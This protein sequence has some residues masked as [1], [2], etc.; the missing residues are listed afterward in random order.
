MRTTAE[1]IIFAINAA[2]R[3]GRN[4]Q[5][6]YAKS[7]KSKAIVLPLPRIIN[8][9]NKP[10][11]ARRFFNN[12]S[13]VNGGAQFVGEIEEL[14]DLHQ[15]ANDLGTTRPLS[16][17]EWA[18]YSSYFERFKTTLEAGIAGDLPADY[19]NVEEL[20]ALLRIRQ[21]ERGK[22]AGT[23]PLQIVAGTLVEI[24]I[25]YFNQV[26]GALNRESALGRVMV[27]FLSAV[28]D[29]PFADKA[30]MRRHAPRIVPQLFIA[31]AESV[32]SLSDELKADP[33]IQDFI[34]TASQG[35]ASDLFDR[36][37]NLSPAQEENA[38]KWGQLLLRATV[39]NAAGYVF[40]GPQRLFDLND[41]GTELIKKTGG[42]LLE[43]ILQDPDRLNLAAGFNSESLDRL[44]QTV[45]AVIAQHPKLIDGRNGFE[46]IV[47]GV[48]GAMSRSAFS[49]PDYL[50]ELVRLILL[51]SANNLPEIWRDRGNGIENLL[52]L[53]T[54]HILFAFTETT[55][56]GWRPDL[57]KDE[58]LTIV[59]SLLESTAA[60]P[61]WITTEIEGIPLLREVI[62]IILRRLAAAPRELRL[63]APV[64]LDLIDLVIVAVSRYPGLLNTLN[65]TNDQEESLVLETGLGLIIDA[66]LRR[67]QTSPLDRQ[68]ALGFLTDYAFRAVLGPHIG[69]EGILILQLLAEADLM[70]KAGRK[71]D[72]PEL[73]E[74]I[75]IALLVLATYPEMVTRNHALSVIIG[76]IA[77][78]LDTDDF[79]GPF[80]TA[81]LLRLSLRITAERSDLIV[82]ADQSEPRYLAAI[83]LADA[84]NALAGNTDS[85]PW[86]PDLGA[87]RLLSIV[88]NLLD[89]LVEEPDWLLSLQ[90]DDSLWR[91]VWQ[92]VMD[93]LAKL[94]AG[95]RLQPELLELIVWNSLRAATDN[96]DILAAIHWGDGDDEAERSLLNR[97][98]D[99][100]ITF[101][102]PEDFTGA[103]RTVLL[104]DI[105]HFAF[106]II[107]SANPDR[108][109][110][111]LLELL[112]N[113]YQFEHG[114]PFDEEQAQRLIDVGLDI[115]ATH[116]ELIAQEEIWQKMI[117]DL[118]NTLDSADLPIE[119]LLPE[120]IRL[121]LRIASGRLPQL[122]DIRPGSSR[123]L[124]ALAI[125]QTLR[126]ITRPQGR[127]RG[128]RPRYT[129]ADLLATLEIVLEAVADHPQWVKNKFLQLCLN[130]ILDGIQAAD[131][132]QPLP[133][134]TVLLF[135]REGMRAVR[136]RRRWAIDFVDEQGEEKQ[137]LLEYAVEGLVISV[138]GDQ[139]SEDV[140]WTLSQT[141]V[142]E[143][144]ALAY[145]A[146]LTQ[147]PADQGL[148][149]QLKA[150]IAQSVGD[151]EDNLA[152]TVNDLIA[153]LETV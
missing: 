42:V 50:P 14:R 149:E 49:Q 35:I 130:A 30:K 111:L 18:T 36:L 17:E 147:G 26:P 47:V 71:V 54:Q 63:S 125:E 46:E 24:G 74:L 73:D 38:V 110:L 91:S 112:L 5:Q 4:T 12:Q 113:G 85:G 96:P 3:L 88:E 69:P 89:R 15:R 93:S 143:A 25:D 43:S 129:D 142:F 67:H 134:T 95:A 146:Q 32:G 21:W 121:S 34:R 1:A 102:Y 62:R 68:E 138:H 82:L 9:T 55:P 76:Q 120:V 8:E 81:N 13:E 23:Q 78:Q 151:L 16:D 80:W 145:F 84:L 39:A 77:S 48:S 114:R 40:D 27:H 51:H 83:A 118:A 109:G 59:N 99:L 53:A 139:V 44:F 11:L 136:F 65:W 150:A 19:V 28:N 101:A 117:R 144:V 72:A 66:T 108:K 52:L 10:T 37:E 140:Q 127:G 41:G 103:E 92:A 58:L 106:A 31:A 128:W 7:L 124:L 98:L 33:K 64:L 94:P 70:P 133:L 141:E 152:W 119:H 153:H 29:I 60:N 123:I 107:L 22:E 86:R 126:A 131:L 2:I 100:I 104:E 122:M 56:D 105:V 90:G 87:P 79:S 57:S 20:T 137:L 61:Q 115:M 148:I 45:F 135:I 6:A 97:M 132:D 116:P 75:E